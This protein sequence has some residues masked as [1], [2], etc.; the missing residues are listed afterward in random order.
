M[1][2]EKRRNLVGERKGGACSE[3]PNWLNSGTE[4]ETTQVAIC[5]ELSLTEDT[6]K[7]FIGP[8]RPN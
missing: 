3:N 2:G 7:P 4:E 6:M 8:K 5:S 1:G